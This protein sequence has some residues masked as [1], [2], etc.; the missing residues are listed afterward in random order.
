M[1]ERAR[2]PAQPK[3]P[4]RAKQP[5]RPTPSPARRL[6]LVGFMGAGKST[7]GSLV[8]RALGWEFVDLD[9]QVE[10]S[11]GRSV[12]EIV[13]RL[14]LAAFRRMEADA[15]VQALAR[16]RVVVAA[17]GGWAA[18]PGRM[19]ETRRVART[20]WLQVSPATALARV[21]ASGVPR[22]LLEDA[23]DPL[24][25]AEA[26]LAERAPR[27][28]LGDI[29]IDT[30]GKSPEEVAREVLD[31]TPRKPG[32]PGTPGTPGNPRNPRIP[33]TPPTRVPE[34]THMML[35]DPAGP[36]PDGSVSGPRGLARTVPSG[37]RQPS[38]DGPS[39]REGKA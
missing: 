15:G 14:G 39:G 21:A 37:R 33:S 25:T 34:P 16:D 19:A 28:A 1:T 12:P 22:P 23:P 38:P 9:D 32:T 26:L 11:A 17:G 36:D 8:A 6:V 27:Y 5:A 31:R 4:A 10:R 13:R 20:V 35:L 2:E 29:R 3:Q 30:E 18:E 7:V 24:A